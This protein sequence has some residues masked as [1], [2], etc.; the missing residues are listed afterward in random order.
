MLRVDK[1]WIKQAWDARRSNQ[2][3]AKQFQRAGPPSGGDR[4]HVPEDRP[5]RIPGSERS[6][7]SSAGEGEDGKLA[8]IPE[9]YR[10]CR[11]SAGT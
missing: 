4:S 11:K 7:F 1:D 3:L 6:V 9:R 10:G 8:Q 5:L 2:H